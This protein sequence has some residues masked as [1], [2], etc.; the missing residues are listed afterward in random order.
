ME[1]ASFCDFVIAT[2]N[3]EFGQPEIKI[4]CFPPV[5]MVTLPA[6]IGPRAAMD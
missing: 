6:L 3:A 5:A 4:G 2:E 1:L